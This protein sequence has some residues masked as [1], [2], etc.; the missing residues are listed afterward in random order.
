MKKSIFIF[1]IAL[2]LFS[3]TESGNKT[4]E[5]TTQPDSVSVDVDSVAAPAVTQGDSL[6]ADYKEKPVSAPLKKVKIVKN[7]TDSLAPK[8]ISDRLSII[9]E[10]MDADLSAF[11]KEFKRLYPKDEYKV[12]SY[13]DELKTMEISIPEDVR[14]LMVNGLNAQM[15]K[16]KF[17]VMVESVYEQQS[18]SQNRCPNA[19]WHINAI[20]L[21]E[22]WKVTK[23]SPNVIVAVLDCGFDLQHE[24]FQGRIYNPY[25]IATYDNNASYENPEDT[26]GTHVAA[27][28]VG[29]DMHE[30]EGV[31]GVAPNCLFM[32]IK[33]MQNGICTGKMIY[34][35][36]LY[37]VNHGADVINLSIGENIARLDFDKLSLDFQRE[38]ARNAKKD[39]ELM[40]SIA[41]LKAEQKNAIV[42]TSAGNDHVISAIDP[43]NRSGKAIVVCASDIHNQAT[44]FTNYGDGSTV[45][46]PGEGIFSALPNNS[47]GCKDGTSMAAPIV[48]GLV[49]LMKSQ[50]PKITT[51]EVV[52]KLKSTGKS[53]TGNVP[54]LVQADKALS[55][56]EAVMTFTVGGVA[57]KMNKV[58]GGTF[59]MGATAEQG[60]DVFL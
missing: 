25:N 48:T 15:P 32:P 44:D 31:T 42:V 43:K 19:G 40:Y 60:N 8:I 53:V 47:Y 9:F 12:I 55:R 5:G 2:L 46:A 14:D 30:A 50:N 21:R 18:V 34:E 45:T 52:S 37:A 27:L 36:I 7:P 3:C 33:V 59:S 51:A 39:E 41:F 22:A 26:H 11:A 13:N 35:A 10:D 4:S 23:G 49:A 56:D 57:F 20:N 58:E 17:L 1:T 16:F 6:P 29:S 28:A 24:M 54:A 38:Y